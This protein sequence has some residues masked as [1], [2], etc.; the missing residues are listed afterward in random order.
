MSTV[1]PPETRV[2]TLIIFPHGCAADSLRLW[3]CFREDKNQFATP[4]Q[5]EYAHLIEEKSTLS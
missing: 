4:S 2:T 3:T 5:S 1:E